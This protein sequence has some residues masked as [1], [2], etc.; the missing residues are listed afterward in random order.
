MAWYNISNNTTN[1]G[2]DNGTTYSYGNDDGS[3]VGPVTGL[4]QEPA[5]GEE[6]PEDMYLTGQ[7]WS[8]SSIPDWGQAWAK[9][10]FDQYGN[11]ISSGMS[12]ALSGLDNPVALDEAQRRNLQYYAQQ[13]LNPILSNLGYR[14]VINSTTGSE[15]MGNVINR[16]GANAYEQAYKQQLDKVASY[17]KAQSL[18]TALLE[19]TRVQEGEGYNQQPWAQLMPYLWA[20]M[21]GGE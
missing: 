7:S 8:K 15:A 13:E 21:G 18:L 11:K 9:N 4:G 10:W 17:Q 12:S 2:L 20:M 16:L 1:E 6:I 3:I 19:V 14:G 5:A